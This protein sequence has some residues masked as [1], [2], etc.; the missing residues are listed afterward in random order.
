MDGLIG[1][2]TINQAHLKGAHGPRNVADVDKY[3]EAAKEKTIDNSVKIYKMS[4][5]KDG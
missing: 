3:G 1:I 2:D 5:G 4:L